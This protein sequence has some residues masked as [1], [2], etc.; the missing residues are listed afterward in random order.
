MGYL[1]GA[2]FVFWWFGTR[3]DRLGRLLGPHINDWFVTAKLTP[4]SAEFRAHAAECQKIAACLVR[5]HQGTVRSDGVPVVRGGRASRRETLGRAVIIGWT[6]VITPT[7]KQLVGIVLAIAIAIVGAGA[8][9]ISAAEC[10]ATQVPTNHFTTSKA[11]FRLD[12]HQRLRKMLL[13]QEGIELP[14]R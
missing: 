7:A 11:D 4:H 10:S 14:L 3:S 12:D 9:G 6:E 13:G 8:F 5:P 1:L 2:A